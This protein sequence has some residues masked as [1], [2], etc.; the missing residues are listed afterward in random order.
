MVHHYSEFKGLLTPRESECES[1][2]DQ[3]KRDQRKN[4]K[5]QRKISLSLSPSLGVNQAFSL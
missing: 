4:F 3:T 2:K 1:E 5:Y